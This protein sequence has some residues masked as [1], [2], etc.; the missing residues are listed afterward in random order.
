LVS[1]LFTIGA[2]FANELEKPMPIVIILLLSMVSIF[3]CLLT[4]SKSDLDKMQKA[5]VQ[6]DVAKN[7]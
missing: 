5:A 7:K 2:P 4:K 6:A 3:L 1:K